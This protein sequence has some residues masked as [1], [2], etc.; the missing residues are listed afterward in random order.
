MRFTDLNAKLLVL[1]QLCYGLGLLPPYQGPSAPGDGYDPEEVDE[2][3]LAYY[4]D[5]PIPEELAARVREVLFDGG[6]AVQHDVVPYWDGEDDFF[7]VRD[8][9]DIARLPALETVTSVGPLPPAARRLLRSRGVVVDDGAHRSPATIRRRY[10][11]AGVP[12]LVSAERGQ[13]EL[14]RGLLERLGELSAEEL[15][16]GREVRFGGGRF[17]LDRGDGRAGVNWSVF[18]PDPL[19]HAP[20]PARRGARGRV[21]TEERWGTNLGATLRV[22][23]ARERFLAAALAAGEPP[24]P[25]PDFG[26]TLRVEPGADRAA[27]VALE[28]AAPAAGDSGWLLRQRGS[29]RRP[30]R[31]WTTRPVAELWRIRPGALT[32][33]ALPVG[34][35]V[36]LDVDDVVAVTA[37]DGSSRA[38]A[39]L[40]LREGGLAERAPAGAASDGP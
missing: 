40:P 9:G 21:R 13:E 34:F 23:G 15:T 28:R 39:Q 10:A 37:P 29:T 18:T 17:R 8:W 14:V 2:A 4:R 19:S 24:G 35:R 32:V 7:D 25:A 27:E 12:V 3:A 6:L 20:H 11:V 30:D 5:L 36:T 16:A 22:L 38:G 26:D 1:E 33:L 31:E